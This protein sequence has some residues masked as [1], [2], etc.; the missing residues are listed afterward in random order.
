MA[1]LLKQDPLCGFEIA[2]DTIPYHGVR[3]QGRVTLTRTG[4]G[5]LLERLIHRYLE[6]TDSTLAQWLL[7]RADQEYAVR[8]APTW[9]TSWDFSHRM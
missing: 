8:I 9:A 7:S 3:G 5:E 4:A 1:S 2:P 6:G